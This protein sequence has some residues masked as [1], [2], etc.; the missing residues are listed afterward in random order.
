MPKGEIS[1]LFNKHIE[2]KCEYCRHGESI[3]K[4]LEIA[5]RKHGIMSP[6]NRCRSFS[7]DPLR[8]VPDAPVSFKPGDFSEDDF[9]I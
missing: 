7:Y 9:S 3:P 1:V 2:P 6:D 8:R 5:C 4:S